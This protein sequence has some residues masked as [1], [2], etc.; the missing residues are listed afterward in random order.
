MLQMDDSM[1]NMINNKLIMI[2][3]MQIYKTKDNS[4]IQKFQD[5]IH[6]FKLI[7]IRL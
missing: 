6:K 4:E 3:I 1:N 2:A 7:D 5:L